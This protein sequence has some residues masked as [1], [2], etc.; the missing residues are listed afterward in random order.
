MEGALIPVLTAELSN[1]E[2]GAPGGN[3]QQHK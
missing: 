2:P 1:L 3:V